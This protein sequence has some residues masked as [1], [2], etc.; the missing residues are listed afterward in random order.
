MTVAPLFLPGSAELCLDQRLDLTRFLSLSLSSCLS[1][2]RYSL[3]L[4]LS[5]CLFLS[6]TLSLRLFFC[7]S[8][9]QRTLFLPLSF[10]LSPP[11]S[12]EKQFISSHF[13][14]GVCLQFYLI[15]ASTLQCF[16][17]TSPPLSP[18]EN[19]IVKKKREISQNT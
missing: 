8:L 1:P 9:F 7:L 12:K 3:S 15:Y 11:L 5:V 19:K 14:C 10:S 2:F 18:K 6:H 13:F 4:S 16:L 17:F